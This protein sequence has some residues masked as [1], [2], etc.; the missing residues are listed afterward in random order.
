MSIPSIWVYLNDGTTNL[1]LRATKPDTQAPANV[2]GV[3]H[4]TQG[5]SLVTY[6]VGPVWFETTLQITGMPGST[7][8]SLNTFFQNNFGKSFTYTD[9]NNNAFTAYFLDTKLPIV[10]NARESWE[11]N[12]HLQLSAMLK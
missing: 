7:K 3:V 12:L 10:K 9:E 11:C 8:D 2:P 4:R 6:Q 1:Q 5:G